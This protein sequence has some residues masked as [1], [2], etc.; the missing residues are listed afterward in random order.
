MD[1]AAGK[2]NSRLRRTLLRRLTWVGTAVIL[3]ALLG[4]FHLLGW[5][6]DTA[7]LSGTSTSPHR[8]AAALRGVLYALAYF[9][10]T[11]VSPILIIA[12]G[13]NAMLR[14]LRSQ[15][16]DHQVPGAKLHN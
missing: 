2:T 10:A 8:E 6:D 1:H 5:R 12:A 16:S 9:S 3:L 13:L 7:I 4:V 11:V 15:S 14:R